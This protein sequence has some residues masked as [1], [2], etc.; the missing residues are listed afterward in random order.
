MKEVRQRIRITNKKANALQLKESRKYVRVHGIK[1]KEKMSPTQPSTSV[2]HN[3]DIDIT[4]NR[5][6][7]TKENKMK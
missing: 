7:L 3:E 4:T 5:D 2:D 6:S 1:E